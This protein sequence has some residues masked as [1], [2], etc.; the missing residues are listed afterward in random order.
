MTRR[1]VLLWC[2]AGLLAAGL[3]VLGYVAWQYVGTNVVAERAQARNIER[4]EEQWRRLPTSQEGAAGPS[5]TPVDLGDALAIVRVPRFGD[6]YV[7]PVVEGVDDDALSSGLGHFEDS[8]APGGTGNF[9]LA[10]HR[11]TH[12]EP[13]RHIDALQPGDVVTVETARATYTYEIDTDPDDLE[14]D[15][16]D[17]WVIAPEPVNPDDAGTG[18]ADARRLLTLVT[19]AELFHTD[20]R[21]VVFGHLVDTAEK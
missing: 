9:A 17:A 14:V 11:V 8:A 10:G 19:C 16:D 2:G 5:E 6:D 15:D 1:R 13:L 7:M 3:A 4:L 20:E 21:T 18:P 12:G